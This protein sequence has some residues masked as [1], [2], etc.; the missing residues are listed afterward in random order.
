MLIGLLSPL[1][2]LFYLTAVVVGVAFAV[3]W[4]ETSK[5]QYLYVYT[6]GIK[7]KSKSCCERVLRMLLWHASSWRFFF[8]LASWT[9]FVRCERDNSAN[10]TNVNNNSWSRRELEMSSDRNNLKNSRC[11]AKKTFEVVAAKNP[12]IPRQSV[13]TLSFVSILRYNLQKC[14]IQILAHIVQIFVGIFLGC[15]RNFQPFSSWTVC[16]LC[17][18]TQQ[19][20][21]HNRKQEPQ[22][23]RRKGSRM[24]RRVF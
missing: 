24:S 22:N 3:Y 17:L 20:N 21:V 2:M 16:S 18:H 6:R 7:M 12:T 8:Q 23:S 1:D 15:L 19:P 11:W 4:V 5:V 14:W 9:V 13:G 10:N